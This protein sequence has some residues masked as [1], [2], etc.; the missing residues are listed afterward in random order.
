MS[1]KAASCPPH[2][3]RCRGCKGESSHQRNCHTGLS[4]PL[5]VIAS[6]RRCRR[7]YGQTSA[8]TRKSLKSAPCSA[9][10]DRTELLK[11]PALLQRL[12]FRNCKRSCGGPGTRMDFHARAPGI[13]LVC[14]KGESADDSNTYPLQITGQN[15]IG[16]QSRRHRSGQ[17]RPFA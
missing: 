10:I 5:L 16:N 3:S 1:Q 14:S 2:R 11:I 13:A 4:P 15:G 12:Q 9:G 7:A 17:A 8:L 6:L